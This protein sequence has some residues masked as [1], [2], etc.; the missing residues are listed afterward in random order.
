MRPP[1]NRRALLTKPRRVSVPAGRVRQ[2]ALDKAGFDRG[3]DLLRARALLRRNRL[4][5][6]ENRTLLRCKC[7][8]ITSSCA[9]STKTR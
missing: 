5:R 8:T 7:R 1:V 4:D 2:V 3:L 6:S 9:D